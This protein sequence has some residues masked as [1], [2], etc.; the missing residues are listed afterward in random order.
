MG[1]QGFARFFLTH[2]VIHGRRASRAAAGAR[3]LAAVAPRDAV[4]E[5]VPRIIAD[6]GG[7]GSQLPR[8]IGGPK[9][10]VPFLS[11]PGEKESLITCAC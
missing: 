9:G 7:R 6:E 4:R 8:C 10:L 5:T 11:R 1:G 2:R 3:S